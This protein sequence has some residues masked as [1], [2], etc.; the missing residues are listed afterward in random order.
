MENPDWTPSREHGQGR[1]RAKGRQGDD[2]SHRRFFYDIRTIGKDQWTVDER[3]QRGSHCERITG[4]SRRAR[5]QDLE[6]SRIRSAVGGH[7]MTV[8]LTEAEVA[9]IVQSLDSVAVF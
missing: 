5:S 7:G 6:R 2:R 9:M 8:S 3:R 1:T 4:Q